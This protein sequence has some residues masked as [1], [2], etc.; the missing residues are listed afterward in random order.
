MFGE[1]DPT[2]SL[3]SL[4]Q[5]SVALKWAF[6]HVSAELPTFQFVLLAP[7]FVTGHQQK[8]SSSI[9]L[10]SALYIFVSID[11]IPPQSRLQAEQSQISQPVLLRQMLHTPNYLSGLLNSLYNFPIFL[12]PRSP[13]LDT[14]VQ[15]SLTRAE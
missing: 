7:C 4:F 15:I 11:K 8:E 3:G 9:H 6:P 13:E 10:T 14:L 2:A 5:C 12:E 1:G